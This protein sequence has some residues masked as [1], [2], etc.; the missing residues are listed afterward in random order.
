MP[1]V[2]TLLTDMAP[3]SALDLVSRVPQVVLSGQESDGP[4]IILMGQ[5]RL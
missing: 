1:I 2:G 3:S 4:F 5:E